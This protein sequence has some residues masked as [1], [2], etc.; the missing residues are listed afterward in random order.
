M[1]NRRLRSVLSS[2]LCL[3]LLLS[4]IPQLRAAASLAMLRGSGTEADPHLI[5]NAAELYA[6]AS[7][8]NSGDPR[9]GEFFLLTDDIVLNDI[10]DFDE[11][12][13]QNR[14]DNIWIPIGDALIEEGFEDGH[15]FS[16][17]FDGGGHS[18]TGAY[19]RASAG[20]DGVGLFGIMRGG[21]VKN[22]SL[23]SFYIP[24]NA[25]CCGG[26]AGRAYET[27]FE[28]CIVSGR[29]GAV[30]CCGGIVGAL[31]VGSIADCTASVHIDCSISA[32]GIAGSCAEAS[33]IGC[34]SLGSIGGDNYIGGIAG[35]AGACTFMRCASECAVSSIERAGAIAG[36][37]YDSEFNK[38]IGSGS[39]TC[40]D[41]AGGIAG[42]CQN[43]VISECESHA[44]VECGRYGGGAAGMCNAALID[45]FR[46][47]GEVSGEYYIGGVAGWS[48]NGN[49]FGS[50]IPSARYYDS[51]ATITQCV[52]EAR[53]SGE[54]GIGG[55]VGDCHETEIHDS[56]NAGEVVSIEYAGGITGYTA[57][58]VIARC[59]TAGTVSAGYAADALIGR[60][61]MNKTDVDSCYYLD[62]SCSSASAHGTALTHEEL[63]LAESYAGF[64]FETV[65][66]ILDTTEY[67]YA[68]LRGLCA[69]SAIL[70]GDI[71]ESGGVSVAD[72]VLALRGAMGLIE[73]SDRQQLAGDM[74]SDGVV[75]V[76]D[77]VSIMRI[78]IG[79]NDMLS[80]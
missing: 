39:V 34:R 18:I 17:N 44:L 43:T 22:L 15:Y 9:E 37:C 11:W 35:L 40:G 6:L 76:A 29:A 38:C 48:H 72:A 8:V 64:D 50:V 65:W 56:Y 53:I 49:D 52:N 61:S 28:N 74:N 13:S 67:P 41:Y 70:P 69:G 55:I 71:D 36:F 79:L 3:F 59:Y 45:L 12:T 1:F 26:I 10:S 25:S 54:W 27:D 31:E 33:V 63:M 2:V 19:I 14:P 78:A 23:H 60:N 47:L 57:D 20:L 58:C 66:C 42:L 68:E 75:S 32:G 30:R 7:S 51:G 5:S 62:T 24:E 80:R 21:S 73:L 46:N 4:F 77:A 16:G